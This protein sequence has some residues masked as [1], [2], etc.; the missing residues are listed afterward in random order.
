MPFVVGLKEILLILHKSCR[1]TMMLTGAVFTVEVCGVMRRWW[2]LCKP[3]IVT[4][5]LS[6]LRL[7]Y[8]HLLLAKIDSNVQMHRKKSELKNP[9]CISTIIRTAVRKWW[10][11]DPFTYTRPLPWTS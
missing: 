6:P 11:E 7:T 1:V 4:P 10:S 5:R 3:P 2:G 9:L 8:G